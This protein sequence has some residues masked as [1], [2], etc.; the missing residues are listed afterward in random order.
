[1]IHA[2]TEGMAGENGQYDVAF[3]MHTIIISACKHFSVYGDIFSRKLK[4][5]HSESV[6]FLQFA[7]GQ[8]KCGEG[9]EFEGWETM[10]ISRLFPL[11]FFFIFCSSDVSFSFP[12]WNWKK[13]ILCLRKQFFPFCFFSGGE[14]RA[15]LLFLAEFQNG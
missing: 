4:Y 9:H 8:C 14:Q 6:F 15:F 10:L 2:T 13:D 5:I 3:F 7:G 12:L 11:F 1:M